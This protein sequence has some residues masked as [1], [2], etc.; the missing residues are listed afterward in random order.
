MRC[1][2]KRC[3][4]PSPT[5]P[6]NA[7]DLVNRRFTAAR[8]DQL[9]VADFTYVPMAVS[10][11][12]TALVIDAFAGHIVGWECSLS[13]HTAFRGIGDPAGHGLAPQ[14]GTSADRGH[15][16]PQR[17]AGSQYTAVHLLLEGLIPSIGTA[18][19]STTP[20]P[21]PPS[22]CTKPSAC[23]TAHRSG[24]GLSPPWPTWRRSLQPGCT[25]QHQPAHAPPQPTPTSGSRGRL[26]RYDRPGQ[27][28]RSHKL[29]CASNPGRFSPRATS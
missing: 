25:V 4:P 13:K 26:L 9:W 15:D 7:P 2:P 5:R 17:F 19:D 11:G 1:G 23:A 18:G 27:P 22:A 24:A 28:G 21:R 6:P 20:S 16:P 10:F 29:R 3:A 12:Y 8:P 14:A